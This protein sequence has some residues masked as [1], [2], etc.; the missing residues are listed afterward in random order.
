[1]LEFL[2]LYEK[3][4]GEFNEIVMDTEKGMSTWEIGCNP[5]W[6]QQVLT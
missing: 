4:G 1:M 2:G 5:W 6:S 3:L